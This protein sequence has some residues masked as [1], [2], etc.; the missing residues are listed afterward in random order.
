M[1]HPDTPDNIEDFVEFYRRWPALREDVRGMQ[2]GSEI[3]SDQASIIRW[4]VLVIDR[5]GPADFDPHLEQQ[6]E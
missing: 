6:N 2:S 3:S 5:V 4:M 1:P